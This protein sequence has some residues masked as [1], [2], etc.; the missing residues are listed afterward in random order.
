MSKTPPLLQIKALTR[1]TF[2]PLSLDLAVGECVSIRGP[3]GSGKSQL[4][5]AIAELDPAQGEL[6][7][8]GVLSA[9]MAAADW[10]RQVALL[11]PESSWWLATA[12]EHFVNGTPVAVSALDLDD[13]LLQQPVTRLSSGERQRLALLRLL[14][15]QPRVLL[16][17][18]PTANLDA[19]NT[20]RVEHLITGYLA[21][22]QAAALWVSHDA[23][24]AG[25][26]ATRMLQFVAGGSHTLQ[27]AAA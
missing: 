26:V 2:A 22:Q 3:S 17:D 10:R 9:D 21:E 20:R 6:R 13:D 15:N 1:P 18:E 16:L 25:R 5:R 14:A 24:Q 27:D 11:P 19:D 4:L 23:A 8:D 12:G 7:L